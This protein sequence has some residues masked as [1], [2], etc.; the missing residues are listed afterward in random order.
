MQEQRLTVRLTSYWNLIRKEAPI[1][2]FA[3][4]NEGVIDDLWPNC[5]LFVG[6]PPV[7]GKQAFRIQRV[8]YKLESLFGQDFLGKEVSRPTF[9]TFGNGKIA[10]RA[11]EACGS[12]VPVEDEGSYVNAQN[13]VVKY[14]ACLLPFAADPEKLSHIIAGIS[15]REM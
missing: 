11:E 3:Q 8:G 14:R 1:P 9:R 13:K 12:R 5:F 4:F 10:L 15:W 6:Q 7:A 2:Q